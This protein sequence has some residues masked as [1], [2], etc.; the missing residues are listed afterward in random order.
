MNGRARHIL[1]QGEL[2][3]APGRSESWNEFARYMGDSRWQLIVE[4]T[5]FTGQEAAAPMVEAMSTKAI[6]KWVI[7]RDSEEPKSARDSVDGD[8]QEPEKS[9]GPRAARLRDIAVAEGAAHCIACLDGWLSGTW[10]V[11]KK[12]AA[13]RVLDVKGLTRRAVWK[14]VYHAVYEVDTSLGPA[15]MYPP[16]AAGESRLVMKTE[17]SMS[18]GRKVKLRKDQ[19]RQVEALKL[20]VQ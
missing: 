3:D 17:G 5:D 15:Y 2:S 13:V 18:P 11:K 10:P 14:G 16:D 1:Y 20:A 19:L 7:E 6:A 8:E 12:Q 4:G 9:L